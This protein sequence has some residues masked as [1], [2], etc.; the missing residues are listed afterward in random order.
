MFGNEVQTAFHE[1]LNMFWVNL[2][3]FFIFLDYFDMLMLKIIF[4]KYYYNIFLNKKYFKKHVKIF[5]LLGLK[6][7]VLHILLFAFEV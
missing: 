1:I 6:M 4:L 3:Y 7:Y 2:I 5:L